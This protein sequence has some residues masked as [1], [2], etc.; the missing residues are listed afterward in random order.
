MLNN[1]TAEKLRSMKLPALAAEYIRQLE[2]PNMDALAFDERV[3]MMADAE[4]LARENNRIKKL[5]KEANLRISTAC[6]ADID[7]R[8]SRKLDRAYLVRLSD[9]AWVKESKNLIITGATG[10]GK[11]WLAC[12]FGAEACQ[13]GIRTIFYRTDRLLSELAV[14]YGSG[15]LNKLLVK[16]K[17]ANILILD[18]WGLA[19]LN[20]LESRFLLEVFEDRYGERS[21]VISAQLPVSKW[22]GLFEDSTIAD[23]IL[24]RLVHNSHRLELQGPSLRPVT[25]KTLDVGAPGGGQNPKAGPQADVS[26]NAS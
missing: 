17:K 21:T 26:S 20:A 9:F 18:D 19:T 10:T 14:A 2:T 1:Q 3:G 7:Y 15:T 4:W 23:A 12:A 24:D 16:L 8:P 5:K 13:K 22:H 6:F 11:T 25:D